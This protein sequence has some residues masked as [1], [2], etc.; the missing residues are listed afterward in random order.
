MPSSP[1]DQDTRPPG[2]A[3]DPGSRTSLRRTARQLGVFT[4]IGVVMT[5]AY[6]ALYAVLRG[7]LGAQG[8]NVVAWVVTAVAD[9]SANRRMTFGIHGRAGALRAQVEG[10]VVFGLGL[11]ITSGSLYAL[12]ALVA[13]PGRPLELGVLAVANLAAGLLRFALLR[14]W[15]FAPGRFD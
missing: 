11:G 14:W 15:V 12:E 10:L 9:T 5:V 3:P 1:S 13:A 2:S 7:T 6:L 8:S 4:G